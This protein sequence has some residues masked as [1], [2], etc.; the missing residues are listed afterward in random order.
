MPKEKEKED[1]GIKFASHWTA[2]ENA[3]KPLSIPA[4]EAARANRRKNYAAIARE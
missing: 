3:N 1:P 4:I 2:E